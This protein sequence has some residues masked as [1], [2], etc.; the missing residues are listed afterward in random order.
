MPK[1]QIIDSSI[2][3]DS[4]C[5]TKVTTM[6]YVTELV[7]MQ[8]KCCGPPIRKFNGDYYID[9]RT[10]E[11]LEYDHIEN[12]SQDLK[13][14]RRT[15]SKI[16]ALINTNVTEPKNC[17]WVT[18]TYAENMT[19]T[20]RLYYDFKK[21]WQRFCYWCE[22]NSISRPEYISVQEPQGRGAWHVHAFFIWHERAPFIPNDVMSKLWGH[23]FTKTQALKDVDNIGAYFSAYLADM[24]LDEVSELPVS[25][26]IQSY[27]ASGT[28]DSK[29]FVDEQGLQ[30][31]KKFVKGG[32]LFLYPAKMNIIRSSAGIKEPIIERMAYFEAKKKVSSA[33]LTFSRSF[34]V[35][36]DSDDVVNI[37]CHEYYNSK[38][39]D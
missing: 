18:L 16:R 5:E 20:K 31:E 2:K 39:K 12:R 10:G 28:I 19:D 11:L 30:K 33:K 23:G 9:L 32:R 13:G 4:F 27:S 8:K 6:G 35:V 36:D 17:R 15:L 22:K 1:V 37:I 14:I 34:S 26:Q 7:T 29:I 3:L 38:C 21:F 24:P 25:E